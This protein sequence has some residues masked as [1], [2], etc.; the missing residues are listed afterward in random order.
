MPIACGAFLATNLARTV[1][2]DGT[3][4]T[5]FIERAGGKRPGCWSHARKGLVE[6]AQSGDAIALD[7]V[8]II[9]RLFA[10]ERTSLLAGDTADERRT[11]RQEYARPVGTR[12]TEPGEKRLH[13][14][15][16]QGKPQYQQRILLTAYP[17]GAKCMAR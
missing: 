12:R 14:A 5:N 17:A 3:T 7:G 15:R 16:Q 8:R 6:A 11:R 2:C 1:Q 9:A 10:V 4:V 13:L